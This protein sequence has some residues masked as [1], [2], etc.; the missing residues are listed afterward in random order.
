MRA[1][2]KCYILFTVC[3]SELEMLQVRCL[4]FPL[5]KRFHNQL[6]FVRT[7]I[8]DLQKNTSYVALMM[9][10]RSVFAPVGTVYFEL[11]SITRLCLR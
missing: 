9:I 1:L 4:R 7:A 6:S 11:H 5:E 10:S 2:R 3:R 8:F